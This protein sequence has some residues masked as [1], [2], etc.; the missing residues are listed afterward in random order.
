[1][2]QRILFNLAWDGLKKQRKIYLPYL[3]SLTLMMALQYVMFSLVNNSYVQNRHAT[4]PTLVMMGDFFS[5]LLTGIFILY[6]NQFIT[7]QRQKEFALYRVLGLEDRHIRR[8]NFY[9]VAII[10]LVTSFGSLIVGYV[11]GH[12]LF[13]FLNRLMRDTGAGIMDYPFDWLAALATVLALF[14]VCGLLFLINSFKYTRIQPSSLLS[15]SQAGE[16]TS[17]WTGL[18][19]ILGLVTLGAGYYIAFTTQGVLDSLLML[20]VAIFLVIIA[21]FALM[22]SLSAM[23]LNRLKQK[24]NY[25]Y[26]SKHFFFISGMLSRMKTNAVS[27]AGIAVL[28]TGIV[29]ALGTTMT[30]YLGMDKLADQSMVRDYRIDSFSG[31]DSSDG[32]AFEPIL[33]KIDQ[34]R[35]VEDLIRFKYFIATAHYEDGQVEA[36]RSSDGP[37]QIAY[38]YV[39]DASAYQNYYGQEANLSDGE[40]L[41][42]S[43]LP[44]A[45]DLDKISLGGDT[46]HVRQLSEDHI[47]ANYV[48][49][50]FYLVVKDDQVLESLRQYYEKDAAGQVTVPLN[51]AYEFSFNLADGQDLTEAEYDDYDSENIGHLIRRQDLVAEI[52][53]MNGGFL[54]IGLVVGAV[55]II[56][57]VLMLYFKQLSEGIADRDK[58]HTM[59]MVGLPQDLIQSTIHQQVIWLFSLPIIIAVI[60]SLAASKIIF[61]LLGLLAIKD[62]KIFAMGYGSVL[63]GFILAYYLI[64]KLTSNIYYQSINQ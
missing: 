19:L 5:V 63:V 40:V 44:P 27:L 53:S 51:Y 31:I 64:Y 41:L 62:L 60:H 15:Q 20:F 36:Q 34:D 14:L 50:V 26:Q 52:Y 18:W 16:K 30:L 32:Q 29:L 25:Y 37:K 10:W 8:L 1:M 55:L 17:R 38:L 7:K 48:G 39:L 45:Q 49:N 22:I 54:F 61:Q 13:M 24:K 11:F 28:A 43:N 46:Y 2:S 47:P 6:A 21:T 58:Y 56:G 59:K 42:A 57:V 23:V 9:E 33:S 12:L 4:L 3:V 35:Q